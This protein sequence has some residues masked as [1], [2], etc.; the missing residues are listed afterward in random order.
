MTFEPGTTSEFSQGLQT[1]DTGRAYQLKV[2]F[3]G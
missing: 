3:K 1:F 2:S